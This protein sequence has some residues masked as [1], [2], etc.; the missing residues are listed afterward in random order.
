MDQLVN[1]KN[2]MKNIY[3]EIEKLKDDNDQDHNIFDEKNRMN[4]QRL[5]QS[6]QSNIMDSKQNDHSVNRISFGDENQIFFVQQN[7]V[8]MEDQNESGIG[9]QGRT[10]MFQN[11]EGFK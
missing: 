5:F 10:D 8:Q 3:S 2:D 6:V 11:E 7:S 4:Y 9:D 1:V